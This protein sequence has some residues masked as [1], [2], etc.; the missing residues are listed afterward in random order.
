M[1][2]SGWL[3]HPQQLGQGD[4]GVAGTRAPQHM[5]GGGTPDRSPRFWAAA[6]VTAPAATQQ[7]QSWTGRA[8]TLASL[9]WPEGAV[10]LMWGHVG[11]MPPPPG[12]SIAPP[13]PQHAA[14]VRQCQGGAGCSSHAGGLVAAAAG[15]AS[16]PSVVSGPGPRGFTADAC[17]VFGSGRPPTALFACCWRQ[18]WG[19]DGRAG[20]QGGEGPCAPVPWGAMWVPQL[21]WQMGATD[22]QLMGHAVGVGRACIQPLWPAGW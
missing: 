11:C 2:A 16:K 19:L 3:H 5:T 13:K 8:Y 12:A 6:S 20:R 17:A 22:W 1:V 21:C 4:S 7:T 15:P 9:T 14:A 10:G 18:G